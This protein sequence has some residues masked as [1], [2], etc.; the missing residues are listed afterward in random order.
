M[1]G[2][3]VVFYL[4]LSFI[5]GVYYTYKFWD[6]FV[7]HNFKDKSIFEKISCMILT[8]WVFMIVWPFFLVFPFM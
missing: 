4:I 1:I 8:L 2:T 7:E 3:I 6:G 5:I